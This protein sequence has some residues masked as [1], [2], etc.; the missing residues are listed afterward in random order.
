MKLKNSIS[1]A[2]LVVLAF[3]ALPAQA[4]LDGANTGFVM[5]ATTL[6][7]LMTPAGLALFYGGL[8]QHKNVL[9]TIGM[10]YAAFC[11]AI[12]TWTCL[13]Y[14]LAFSEGNM[15]IGGLDNVF[16]RNIDLHSITGTIPTYSF[17]LFQGT[18]AAI[19]VAIVSGSIIERVRFSFW[20]AFC[21]LWVLLVYAPIAHWVWGGGMLSHSGEMDFAG[22]TVVHISAGVSGLVLALLLGKR[23]DLD[24]EYRPYS[25]VIALLGSALLWFGWFGF[26]AGSALA[27]DALAANAMLL[28]CVAGSS[29]A[30]AW[31][32]AE[33]WYDKRVSLLGMASGVV[34]GLVGITPASG[35]VDFTG[36]LIIGTGSGLIGLFAVRWM[37][38]KLG[39]DDSLDAFGIHGVV[40]IFGSLATGFLANPAIN[41]NVGVFY[42][43]A[44]AIV[45]QLITVV[46]TATYA[47]AASACIFF[48]LRFVMRGRARVS[49]TIEIRGM[50]ADFHKE[51]ALRSWLPGDGEKQAGPE[52]EDADK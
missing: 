48:V 8:T 17:V 37:K 9:N 43:K 11:L 10:N 22:G 42:G 52:L 24:G 14:T 29:G 15:L 33:R 31:S 45:P 13:G 25:V 51:E 44:Y 12:L 21:I 40:G 50:D 39:Y 7:M 36:A 47:A 19:A 32:M 30:A 41:N 18:F 20:V 46:V 2:T 49:G 3:V 28:T 4:A 34:A 23:R 5:F 26:N 27:A 1:K 38:K 16:L 6:V 35:Y